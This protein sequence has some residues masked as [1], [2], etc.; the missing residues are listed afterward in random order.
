MFL[1][2]PLGELGGG[3]LGARHRANV[4][5]VACPLL[6]AAAVRTGRTRWGSGFRWYV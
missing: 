5:V 2:A 1:L 4:G 3:Q 6:H